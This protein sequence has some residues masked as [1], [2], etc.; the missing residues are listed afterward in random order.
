L[1][2]SEYKV[3]VHGDKATFVNGKLSWT[4]DVKVETE[5]RKFGSTAVRFVVD[6]GKQNITEIRIGGTKTKLLF[7]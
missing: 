5:D 2:A 7:N 1:A 6:A 3:T 4:V